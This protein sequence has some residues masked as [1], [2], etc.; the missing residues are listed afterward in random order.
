MV[1]FSDELELWRLEG[2]IRG[3]VNVQEEH[4]AGEG[5]VIRSHDGCLPVEKVIT[6]GSSG[7]LCRWIATQILQFLQI[8]RELVISPN[9]HA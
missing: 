4:T 6:N 5:R 2:V 9:E 1:Y 7:A 8:N 3:E